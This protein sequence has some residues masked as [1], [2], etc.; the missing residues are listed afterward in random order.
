MM[1]RIVKI[2]ISQ[3]I[4]LVII[5]ALIGYVF[6]ISTDKGIKI[7]MHKVVRTAMI[8][9]V[10]PVIR[11]D[12]LWLHYDFIINNMRVE[13]KKRIFI[14]SE[15]IS[16]VKDLLVNKSLPIVVDSTDYNRNEMPITSQD[17]STYK[18]VRPDSLIKLYNELDTLKF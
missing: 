3:L 15:N 12:G 4:F 17:F 9:K 6:I 8:T 13:N 2:N 16:K 7:N 5:F 18:M 1:V 11:G 10:E 14:G